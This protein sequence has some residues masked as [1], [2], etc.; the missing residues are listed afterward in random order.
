[1]KNFFEKFVVTLD[2]TT[3]GCY[4]AVVIEKVTTKTLGGINNEKSSCNM[5]GRQ[6][7]KAF[8]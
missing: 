3:K 5:C 8:G 7:G 1:M 2:I 6:A 4:N